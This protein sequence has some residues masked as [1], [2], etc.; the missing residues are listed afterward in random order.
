M[1]PADVNDAGLIVGNAGTAIGEAVFWPGP[2]D[3]CISLNKFLKN[4]AFD[5]LK[6]A[7]A[8]NQSG[9]IV[10]YGRINNLNLYPAFLGDSE[11]G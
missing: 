11:I 4:S 1:H 2:A 5:S 7:E 3:A 10:G 6:S 9:D 8:V